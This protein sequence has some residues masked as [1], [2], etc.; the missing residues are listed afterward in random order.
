MS[1]ARR[2]AALLAVA[3]VVTLTSCSP[4]APASPPAKVDASSVPAPVEAEPTPESNL[5]EHGMVPMTYEDA[6]VI[7]YPGTDDIAV[8]MTVS[9]VTR[10]FQCTDE[11]W[12]TYPEKGEHVAL[13]MTITTDV[14]YE[15]LSGNQPMRLFWHDFYY[16]TADTA[17][18]S[19]IGTGGI[20]CVPEDVDMPL[21]IPAGQTITHPY[22]IDVPQN[23][24]SITW[25]PTTFV[26]PD[27]GGWEWPLK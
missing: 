22:I 25:E 2:L 23:A 21:D 18:R 8:S 17:E 14:N 10:N 13:N 15:K 6:A 26:V 19:E 3:G 11:L 27:L 16:R 4:A 9:S 7:Y 5:N 12:A 1:S 24:T 20:G